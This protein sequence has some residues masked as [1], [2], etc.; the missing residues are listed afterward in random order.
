MPHA[1]DDEKNET[2]ANRIIRD[3]AHSA[4]VA[5]AGKGAI[6]ERVKQAWIDAHKGENLPVIGHALYRSNKVWQRQIQ[7][8]C[9]YCARV[10]RHGGDLGERLPAASNHRVG[11]CAGGG[12]RGGYNIQD[13]LEITD[14]E[15]SMVEANR[16]AKRT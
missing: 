1:V 10:H 16:T 15:K 13:E 3:W 7:V 9:Y 8:L 11:H 6:P 4:G 2:D 5:V 14:N 12:P